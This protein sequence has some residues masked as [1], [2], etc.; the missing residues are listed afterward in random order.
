[1]MDRRIDP[2]LASQ[3]VNR[4]QSMIAEHGDLPIFVHDADTDW[5]LPVG[6]VYA[7]DNEWASLPNPRIEIAASYYREPDGYI[8]P[9]ADA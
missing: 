6:I 7:D 1:M 4:L 2:C 8:A 3:L 9:K 5:L